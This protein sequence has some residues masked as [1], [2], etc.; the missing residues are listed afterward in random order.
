MKRF[1]FFDKDGVLMSTKHFLKEF[2]DEWIPTKAKNPS[3]RKGKTSVQSNVYVFTTA[4]MTARHSKFMDMKDW[5][6]VK[7]GDKFWLR[8]GDHM[9]VLPKEKVDRAKW[10]AI[11]QGQVSYKKAARVF[12][13]LS[14]E[15]KTSFSKLPT[16]DQIEFLNVPVKAQKNFR[17]ERWGLGPL[18][19]YCEK[20]SN[21]DAIRQQRRKEEDEAYEKETRAMWR[22]ENKIAQALAYDDL[23]PEAA[24]G[25]EASLSYEVDSNRA[26]LSSFFLLF[27]ES[28][29]RKTASEKLAE[30]RKVTKIATRV[31]GNDLKGV[32]KLIR[33]LTKAYQSGIINRDVL[34]M[35]ADFYEWRYHHKFFI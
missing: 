7:I 16:R 17:D 26:G 24:A 15:D 9:H 25:Y 27:L 30:P 20:M 29:G 28:K 13:N 6:N 1:D 32:D 5:D 11:F 31:T 12:L 18:T 23:R 4:E 8:S 19:K 33:R 14:E 2:P 3:K 22:E 34:K 10:N 35:I 21:I